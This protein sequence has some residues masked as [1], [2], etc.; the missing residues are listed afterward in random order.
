MGTKGSPLFAGGLTLAVG[1]PAQ[2]VG[3]DYLFLPNPWKNDF[4]LALGAS[5]SVQ[6]E[7]E[8]F[9]ASNVYSGF[10]ALNWSGLFLDGEFVLVSREDASNTSHDNSAWHVRAGYNIYLA[11]SALTPFVLISELDGGDAPGSVKLF[12]GKRRVADAGVNWHLNRNRL[13]LGFHAIMSEDATDE[14]ITPRQP[15]REGQSFL[16]TFQ[17]RH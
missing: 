4:G 11:Q 8:Q 2:I 3:A 17:V 16:V 10:A 6:G 7:T 14:G 5:S 9:N 13:Q 1:K 12:A 15:A